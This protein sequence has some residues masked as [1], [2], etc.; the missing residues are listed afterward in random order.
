MRDD[1]ARMSPDGPDHWKVVNAKIVAMWRS[2]P[3][4]TVDDL[5]RIV[6]PFLVLVAD[7]DAVT[8]EHT[9]QLYRALPQGQLAVVPGA[10]HLVPVEKPDDVNRLVVDFLD[11][12]AVVSI[13]PMRRAR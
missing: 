5:A 1:Y 3:R 4:L 7:D 2:S 13:L 12:G 8:L 10:S 9:L 11:D 6:V